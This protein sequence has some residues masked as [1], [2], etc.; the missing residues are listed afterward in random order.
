MTVKYKESDK[1]TDHLL[2]FIAGG[3]PD[4][5]MGES[6]GNYNAVFGEIDASEPL[7]EM[8]L[9]QI[10]VMQNEMVKE[11]G[12]SS[13]TGR[14]Q[15]LKATLQGYQKSEK[16]PINTFFTEEVQDDFGWNKM[17]DRGYEAWW[18]EDISDDEF[19]HRLAM[20]WASLPDPANGGKSF[21]DGDAAGNHASTTVEAFRKALSVARAFINEGGRPPPLVA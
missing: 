2:D 5:E 17:C 1:A 10:Y 4:N 15:A 7:N 19:M 12:I 14:Y 13:A 16:L 6:A 20:E 8:T 11:N 21:Y 9:A 3:V 18:Q